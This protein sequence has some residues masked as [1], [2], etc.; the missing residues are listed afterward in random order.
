MLREFCA[1]LEREAYGVRI[2]DGALNEWRQPHF[3]IR[4]GALHEEGTV[5]APFTDLP[6]M[7]D[8]SLAVARAEKEKRAGKGPAYLI[9]RIRPEF[10]EGYGLYMRLSWARVP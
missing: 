10:E 7:L 9:W 5:C 1:M 3:V 6:T 2:S 4:N 8:Q